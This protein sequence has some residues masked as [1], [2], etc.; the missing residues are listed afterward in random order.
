[1]KAIHGIQ[2]FSEEGGPGGR[3]NS[4]DLPLNFEL[5][6]TF[7]LGDMGTQL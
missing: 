5:P 1:M 4:A 2:H 7:T 6:A 3:G